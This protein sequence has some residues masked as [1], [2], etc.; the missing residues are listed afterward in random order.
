MLSET[1]TYNLNGQ[2]SVL[3]GSCMLKASIKNTTLIS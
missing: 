2:K 3:V 1:Y